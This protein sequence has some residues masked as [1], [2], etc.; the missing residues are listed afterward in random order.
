VFAHVLDMGADVATQS[1]FPVTSGRPQAAVVEA[2]RSR[3]WRATPAH[4]G[5]H[6]A[7]LAE[8][9]RAIISGMLHRG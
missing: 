5:V 8:S 2:M 6:E 4:L 1:D 9:P 3:A 7:E